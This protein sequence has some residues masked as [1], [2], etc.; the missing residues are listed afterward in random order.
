MAVTVILYVSHNALGYYAY[1]DSVNV[2]PGSRAEFSSSL[3]P[4]NSPMCIQ[5][6][7][8]MHSKGKGAMGELAL[9]MKI[10]GKSPWYIFYKKGDQGDGWKFGKANIDVA[11]K[12]YKVRF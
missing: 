11:G 6:W 2:R 12:R 7:Y 5:F 4:D 9:T 3:M 10:N 1:A 8:F